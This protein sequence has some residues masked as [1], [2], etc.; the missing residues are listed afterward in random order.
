ML[1]G[2]WVVLGKRE[3]KNYMIELG[4]LFYLFNTANWLTEK[5]NRIEKNS[6]GGSGLKYWYDEFG[7]SWDFQ[8]EMSISQ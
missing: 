1:V 5:L 7:I 3:N 8:G 2:E 4:I 6:E